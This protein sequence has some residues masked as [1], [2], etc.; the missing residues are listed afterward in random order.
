MHTYIRITASRCF[1][2]KYVYFW[3]Y[4]KILLYLKACYTNEDCVSAYRSC[5]ETLLCSPCNLDYILVKAK[6]RLLTKFVIVCS[7]SVC[8]NC[9][10]GEGKAFFYLSSPS[11]ADSF[12]SLSYPLEC[13][14]SP[15]FIGYLAGMSE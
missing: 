14:I 8:R 7:R 9:F 15:P 13:P 3:A 12:H 1:G 6:L 5:S 10:N 2:T 11:F 4:F